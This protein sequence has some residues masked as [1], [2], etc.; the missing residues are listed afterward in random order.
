MK[1]LSTQTS[2]QMSSGIF[3]ASD[4]D[5]SGRVFRIAAGVLVLCYICVQAFQAYVFGAF[6]A[7]AN[8]GEELSQGAAGLHITR[9][10]IMLLAIFALIFMW[11]VICAQG[12]RKK[13]ALALI[14]FFG[15]FMFGMF[16][17]ALRSVELFWTQIQLPSDFLKAVDSAARAA[18]LDKFATFQS[19]QGALYFPLMFG[20]FLA[21]FAVFFL[22]PSNQRIHWALKFS[23]AFAAA[24]TGVRLLGYAGIH[25]V[26]DATYAQYY[27][28]MVLIEYLPRAYWLFRVKDEDF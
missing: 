14:A 10:S 22:F 1:S 9:S 16:E 3:F 12:L 28:A 27:F 23:I 18:I 15:F 5:Q 2:Q 13:P 17:V 7:P 8:A 11:W 6:G 20:P 19:I 24:R 26:S 21:Y 25:L 4:F